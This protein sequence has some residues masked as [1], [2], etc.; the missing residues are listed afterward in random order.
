MDALSQMLHFNISQS[1]DFKYH[2]R[3]EKTKIDHL[4]FADDL[5]FFFHGDCRSASIIRA[6][7]NQFYDFTGLRANNSKSFFSEYG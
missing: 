5:M 2:W 6:T 7:L 3:C 1:Q 4:C